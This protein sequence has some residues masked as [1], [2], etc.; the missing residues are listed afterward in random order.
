MKFLL[1]VDILAQ[2]GSCYTL[3]PDINDIRLHYFLQLYSKWRAYFQDCI[4]I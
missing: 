4:F 1:G 2:V 3:Y